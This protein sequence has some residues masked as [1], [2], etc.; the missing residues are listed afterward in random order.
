[1]HA[2]LD[3]RASQARRERQPRPQPPEVG[4][5]NQRRPVG[6]SPPG[7][8]PQ[9]SWRRIVDFWRSFIDRPDYSKDGFDRCDTVRGVTARCD[10]SKRLSRPFW[11]GPKRAHVPSRTPRMAFRSPT[12]RFCETRGILSGRLAAHGLRRG[13]RC[14]VLLPTGLDFIRAIY[15][16]Q[17]A[18]AVP[19]AVNPELPA[20]AVT[21]RLTLVRA[22]LAVCSPSAVPALQAD[23]GLPA[24]C[25]IVTL[26]E[27]SRGSGRAGSPVLPEPH[28]PA[29]L[30]LT[31]GTT[32]EP[33]AVIISHRS[34]I[35]SLLATTARLEMRKGDTLATWVPLHHDLGLVR[36]VFGAM[37]AGC[38]AH[39]IRPSIVNLRPWLELIAR[40]RAT[41]TGAPD[42]A[43][44]LAARTVKAEGL[45]LRSLRFAGN[46][47]ETV[48]LTTIE[49]FERR[50]GL[51][52]VVRP[53]YGL[54]EA[55]LTVTSTSP[56]EALRVD[57]SGTV[58]CGRPLDGIELRIADARGRK[59]PA[60]ASGELLVRGVPVFD[61]YFGD[62]SA[63]RATLRNGWLHTGDIASIDAPGLFV[64][65]GTLTRDDQT[66]RCN[67]RA[68]RD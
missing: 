47:G 15:A 11:P 13:G 19:V 56:A 65:Q 24:S 22:R 42:S 64:P 48:R 67:H 21:R 40:V 28:D 36:Y 2:G 45:D 63:T 66:G 37:F 39:L 58:S 10:E 1:M 49:Q 30:Q 61:G 55:T 46:G 9:R 38:A 50:F 17:L 41:I 26:D 33:R 5:L 12:D 52:G 6:A 57:A 16:I 25:T 29:F 62:A 53:A 31:S 14:A 60:G 34:L 68:A 18:G 4:H 44:R 20:G 7:L 54:A 8:R 59:A 32:G 43:Y 23:A 35:A 3:G 27:L 51:P